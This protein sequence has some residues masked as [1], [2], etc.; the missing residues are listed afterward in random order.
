MN[1]RR[2]QYCKINV[3]GRNPSPKEAQDYVYNVQGY[4]R[5]KT[6]EGFFEVKSSSYSERPAPTFTQEPLG[7]AKKGGITIT[8]ANKVSVTMHAGF[9]GR[10]LWTCLSIL[11][12]SHVV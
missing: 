5:E 9:S 7:P 4:P 10:D 2:N 8:F 6:E 1:D 12:A 3:S 11:E